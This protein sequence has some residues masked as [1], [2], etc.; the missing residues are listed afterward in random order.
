MKIQEDQRIDPRIK[1]VFGARSGD[2]ASLHRE[3]QGDVTSR[4]RILEE[5]NSKEVAASRREW[6]AFLDQ[7]DTEEIAPSTGLAITTR[8]VASEPDGNIIN[9]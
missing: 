2:T 8:E 3:N 6:K 9:I 1:Q 4:E 5:A 7:C